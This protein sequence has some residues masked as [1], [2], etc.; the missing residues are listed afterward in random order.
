[1]NVA[2]TEHKSIA[3]KVLNS[4]NYFQRSRRYS[5]ALVNNINNNE[6]V[7]GTRNIS[8]ASVLGKS[9]DR[10]KKTKKTTKPVALDP[11]ELSQFLNVEKLT[12]DLEK[13]IADL[14][15]NFIKNLTIRSST[16][17]I[18]RIE[19]V[20]DGQEYTLEELVQIS[21]KPKTVILNCSAFPQAIPQILDALNKSG[22]NLNP[23]QDGTTLFIPI[24]K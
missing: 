23:Q 7:C 3:N 10:E 2:A 5:T 22:M 19:V 11:N 1:M 4:A 24:P 8:V 13:S 15:D 21:R 6:T 9:K 18:D 20:F 12:S 17:A 14:K 16:G